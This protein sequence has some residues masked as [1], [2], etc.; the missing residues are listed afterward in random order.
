LGLL[1]NIH[2]RGIMIED[3]E[4]VEYIIDSNGNSYFI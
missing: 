3:D 4:V 2:V 1:Y